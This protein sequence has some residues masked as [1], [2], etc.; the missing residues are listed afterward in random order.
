MLSKGVCDLLVQGSGITF[1]IDFKLYLNSNINKAASHILQRGEDSSVKYLLC[2][3]ILIFYLV[4]RNMRRK[5]DVS[6]LV[7]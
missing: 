7:W 6:S 3:Y 1:S 4:F 2:N 5:K